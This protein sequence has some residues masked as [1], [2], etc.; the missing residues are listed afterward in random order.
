[1]YAAVSTYMVD[2]GASEV[3]GL[4]NCRPNSSAG[5]KGSSSGSLSVL[6]SPS[7]SPSSETC[8]GDGR[9]RDR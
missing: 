8:G 7:A 3:S 1:M 4:E 2:V 6:L 9:R 5:G